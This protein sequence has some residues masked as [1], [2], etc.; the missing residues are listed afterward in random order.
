MLQISILS[1]T[2]AQID[3]IY[4][5]GVYR[6]FILHLP[7]GYNPANK[8]PL[9]LNLHGLNSNAYEQQL[10]TQFDAI[11]DDQQMIVVYPNAIN[12]NWS[13]FDDRDINFISH[14]VETLRADYSCNHCLFSMGM[15][16]G[17]FMSYLFACELPKPLTAIAVVTG[18]MLQALENTC[19][20]ENGLPVMH[21]HG[22]ADGVVNYNGSFGVLPVEET[23]QWWVNED[24]ADPTPTVTHLPDIN[25]ID[26]STVEKYYYGNGINGTEVTLYKVINGGHTWPGAVHIPALGNTNQD[27]NASVIIGEFFHQFCTAATAV[28]DVEDEDSISIF[29]NPVDDMLTVQWPGHVFQLS[30]YDI[31]SREIIRIENVNVK[32]I[33]NC[34]SL[35]D[36]SYFIRL[37]DEQISHLEKIIVSK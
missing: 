23:I 31:R 30:V 11:A 3:S 25:T 27:I 14:L 17:G 19:S 12:S 16:Q 7:A 29:P 2:H 34:I 8:Y 24:Q 13:L 6:T 20:V 5:Q 4:D 18:N 28:D 36:G 33:I 1:P 22:T 35:P 10:Y 15:S 9:V 37:S 21:F 26:A 32:T